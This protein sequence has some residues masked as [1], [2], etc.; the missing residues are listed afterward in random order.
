VRGLQ[1]RLKV[2]LRH[3][4]VTSGTLEQ[5]AAWAG[6][7]PPG[8]ITAFCR[9]LAGGEGPFSRRPLLTCFSFVD[10]SSE[11]PAA[12][13]IHVPVRD[14]APNDA[15]LRERVRGYMREQGLKVEIYERCLQAMARRSLADRAGLHAYVSLRRARDRSAPRLTVYLSTEL[16]ATGAQVR[17]Y[18]AENQ[19]SNRS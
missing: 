9:A 4:G 14:Y 1:A 10:P 2:Y 15:V 3:P 8:S 7:H 5:I 6:D 18:A 16:F 17:P 11:R 12:S 13:T 19:C